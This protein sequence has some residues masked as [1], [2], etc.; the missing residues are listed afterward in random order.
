M[1]ITY[2]KHSALLVETDS[3]KVIIDPLLSGNPNSGNLT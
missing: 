2:Y 1:K 3:A